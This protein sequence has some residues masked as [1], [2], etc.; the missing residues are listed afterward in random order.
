MSARHRRHAPGTV[1]RMPVDATTTEAVLRAPMTIDVEGP[2]RCA[3]I[4]DDDGSLGIAFD[5]DLVEIVGED[6]VP[7]WK[8]ETTI[9]LGLEVARA[10]VDLLDRAVR[11]AERKER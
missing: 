10:V 7:G 8:R 2:C 11:H 4:L 3:V 5:V 6:E 9:I 1:R